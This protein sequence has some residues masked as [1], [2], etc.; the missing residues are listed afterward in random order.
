MRFEILISSIFS[1]ARL[2]SVNVGSPGVWTKNHLPV[3]IYCTEI[4]TMLFTKPY[5]RLMSSKYY[6][7]FLKIM[8]SKFRIYQ[9]LFEFLLISC[10]CLNVFSV[11]QTFLSPRIKYFN[12]Y[13]RIVECSRVCH[14]W[15]PSKARTRQN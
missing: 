15:K 1:S 3:C 8:W 5:L 13:R 12:F 7:W 2:I 9:F 6:Y 10:I 11:Y 14:Y 4:S